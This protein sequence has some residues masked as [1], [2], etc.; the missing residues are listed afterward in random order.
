MKTQFD[1]TLFYVVMQERNLPSIH[2]LVSFEHCSKSKVQLI[3]DYVR[4]NTEVKMSHLNILKGS[5]LG[6]TVGI[7]II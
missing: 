1:G 5:L 7:P 2:I 3:S 4:R 6:C